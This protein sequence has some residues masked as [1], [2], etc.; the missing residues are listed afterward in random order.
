VKLPYAHVA[1]V[2]REKI[3]EYLL[4]AAHPDN[5]GKAAFFQSLGFSGEDWTTLSAAFRKLIET[6]EVTMK[7]ESPH[8]WKYILDGC[9]ESPGGKAPLVRTIWIIDRGQ[10]APRLVTAYPHEE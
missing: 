2:E 6:T 9:I 5:G 1:V 4:N 7:L 3:T 8:G 10:E